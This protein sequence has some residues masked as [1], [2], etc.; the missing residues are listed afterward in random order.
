MSTE[1]L[2][3]HSPTI[4]DYAHKL[5]S[6]SLE[7][8]LRR[9]RLKHDSPTIGNWFLKVVRGKSRMSLSSGRLAS[10]T[11]GTVFCPGR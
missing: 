1:R 11:R 3:D 10:V 5:E 6:L 4:V 7:G 8:K 2:N 9:Q